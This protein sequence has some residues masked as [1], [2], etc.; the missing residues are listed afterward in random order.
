MER[1]IVSGGKALFGDVEISGMKNAALPIVV[2]SILT[3][4]KCVIEN[5]PSISDVRKSLDI[6][7]AMGA[8]VNYKGNNSVEI[9]SKDVKGGISPYDLVSKMRGSTYLIGA[10]LARFGRAKVGWPGGCDFGV[11]PIDQHIKGFEAL[12]A[13]VTM[14]TE[15]GYIYADAPNGLHGNSVYFDVVSVGATINVMI[16]AVLAKGK[17]VIDN[18]AREPHIVD[19]A[20]FFNTCG[21][22]ITGAGTSV[23][24]IQGVEK[25][26]GCNY[27]IIPDMIEAGTFMAAVAAT[28]GKVNIKNI[29]PKHMESVS[30]KLEEMGMK[31]EEFDDSI[32]IEK[33]KPLKKI[34]IKTLPYPGFPTDMHPQLTAVLCTAEG[35]STVTEGVWENR[36]R[37]V[38]ELRKMGAE[39]EVEGV[40]ARVNGVPTLRGA[41]VKAVDLRGGAAMIIAG[42]AAKGT[43]EITNIMS[44]ERGYDDIVGKLTAL[45]ADIRKIEE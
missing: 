5:L 12:G 15:N 30:A 18:A 8:E 24:K 27:T 44:I 42:L 43:T 39:I 25:L 40:S 21:A 33:V 20:N 19:L 22:K 4:E 2:A 13:K 29:I 32:T 37:Y 3:G 38:E 16:A 34:Q 23:I 26:H 45:G 7:A 10:E 1:Y 35:M 11:R 41:E 17:T 6:L 28:G 36:F 9:D 14:D 31:I